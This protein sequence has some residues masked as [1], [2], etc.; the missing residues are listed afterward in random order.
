MQGSGDTAPAKYF[1][2]SVFYVVISCSSLV[3][4]TIID[5]QKRIFTYTGE[6]GS[7]VVFFSATQTSKTH[8]QIYGSLY[9][10]KIKFRLLVALF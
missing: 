2:R 10:T 4:K 9:E 7:K 1:Q 3:Q 8:H 5:T 6:V